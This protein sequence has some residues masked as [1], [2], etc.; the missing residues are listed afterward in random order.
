MEIKKFEAISYGRSHDEYELVCTPEEREQLREML[1][2]YGVNLCTSVYGGTSCSCYVRNA[3]EEAVQGW[4]SDLCKEM[5][6]D[7]FERY[8]KM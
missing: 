7:F 1:A 4:G 6:A 8:R 2:H 3:Y 5:A